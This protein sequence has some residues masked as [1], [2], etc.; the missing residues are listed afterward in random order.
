[1]LHNRYGEMLLAV[2]PDLL[3]V[4]EP[5]LRRSAIRMY[6]KINQPQDW[7]YFDRMHNAILNIEGLRAA[8]PDRLGSAMP[9]PLFKAGRRD[10]VSG[11]KFRSAVWRRRRNSALRRDCGRSGSI[12]AAANNRCAAAKSRLRWNRAA[13]RLCCC[14]RRPRRWR[15]S[16]CRARFRGR[17]C[18]CG[19]GGGAP[20]R[21]PLRFSTRRGRVPIF[22]MRGCCGTGH[23]VSSCRFRSTVR[24]GAGGSGCG[25]RRP[26]PRSK[27]RPPEP[28]CASPPRPAIPEGRRG[29][30]SGIGIGMDFRRFLP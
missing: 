26:A 18:R 27:P 24:P 11:E 14:R 4:R 28:R 25:K 9:Q 20:R 2:R 19:C 13:G 15:K 5:F 21:S 10:R 29:G 23:T 7:F 6:G 8:A 16:S 30:K 3:V 12:R 1:M 22:P 17:F